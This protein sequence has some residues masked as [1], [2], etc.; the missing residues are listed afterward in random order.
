MSLKSKKTD[1]LFACD[2]NETRPWFRDRIPGIREAMKNSNY[3]IELVDIY[4]L[5]GEHRYRPTNV[6]ERELFMQNADLVEANKNFESYVFGKNPRILVLGTADNYCE[7]LR[8]S[9]IRNIRNNGIYVAGIL[10]DDE[11]NYSDNRFLIGWFDLFVAYVKDCVKYYEEFEIAE[12][13]YLPNSCFLAGRQFSALPKR[14][15]YDVILVGAP[16]WNR[17]ELAKALVDQAI[18]LAIY[19]HKRW[20]KY[21]FAREHYQGF[22]PTDSFDQVLSQGKIVLAPLENHIDGKLHMNTKIWEAVRVGR[23]PISTSY[24]PLE[25]DYGLKENFD[26]VTYDSVEALVAKVEHYLRHDSERLRIAKNLYDIVSQKFDY[27][28]LYH[29]LFEDLA[30]YKTARAAADFAGRAE[31]AVDSRD[32]LS[33]VAGIKYF[34]SPGSELDSEAVNH[35]KMVKKINNGSI[36]YIYYNRLEAGRRVIS[37]WP[38]VSWDNIIFL[39]EQKNRFAYRLIFFKSFLLGRALHIKQFCVTSQKK[40]FFGRINQIL[41]K[42]VRFFR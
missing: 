10:G 20:K 2:M 16:I 3:I 30:N 42:I 9:T 38:F 25:A 29:T 33:E 31:H 26:I 6:E 14:T 13:Y 39:S 11:F 40:T 28:L 41:R 15:F 8:P 34:G 17:V 37:V 32:F 19:G 1:I 24:K 27:S 35:L 4:D 5:L 7:F 21:D 36:D 23:L 22:I 12:G 18:N